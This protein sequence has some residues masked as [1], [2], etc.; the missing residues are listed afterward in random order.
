MELKYG[1]WENSLSTQL[2]ELRHQSSPML[3]LEPSI[4]PLVSGPWTQTELHHQLFWVFSLQVADHGASQ[5]P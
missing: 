4:S 2:F 1:R 5:P 3:G